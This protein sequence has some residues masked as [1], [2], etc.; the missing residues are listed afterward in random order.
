MNSYSSHSKLAAIKIAVD[1]RTTQMKLHVVIFALLPV[2]AVE[3][4]WDV[5]RQFSG[6]CVCTQV[7]DAL[8][9][10]G[11]DRRAAITGGALTA[12][13]L[14]PSDASAKYR[15]SLA[16]FKGYGSSPVVDD[17]KA[18]Q[19]VQSGLSHAALVANSVKMREE[20]LG[21]KLTEDEVKEIDVRATL[22]LCAMLSTHIGNAPRAHRTRSP[23]SIR[24][25]SD[26][27]H[28]KDEICSGD[29]TAHRWKES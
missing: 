11:F 23:N 6:L 4:S 19:S 14:L 3:A 29:H 28:R 13:T 2:R 12:L 5:V 17:A 18:Q 16:E 8:R 15:P 20:M 21:R 25:P 10:S 24:T 26:R 7:A 22:H 27:Q 1:T 9:L